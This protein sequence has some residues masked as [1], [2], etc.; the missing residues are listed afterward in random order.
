MTRVDFITSPSLVELN[1]TSNG[2][3]QLKLQS[4]IFPS[5]ER[6]AL[7]NNRIADVESVVHDRLKHLIM[8]TC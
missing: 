3:K 5:L 4:N 8:S 7:S 1:L 6:L 2:I